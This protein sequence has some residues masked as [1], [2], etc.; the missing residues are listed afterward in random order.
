MKGVVAVTVASFAVATAG[1]AV[2]VAE[3]S[4][5]QGATSQEC[6]AVY[7]PVSGN[8]LVSISNYGQLMKNGP[9]PFKT[10]TTK[11]P[12]ASCTIE[13]VTSTPT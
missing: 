7:D 11:H 2:T 4:N 10:Y 8:Y 3:A 12:P 5:G 9:T 6:H 1:V 13:T